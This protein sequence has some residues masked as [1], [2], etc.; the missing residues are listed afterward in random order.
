MLV[1]LVLF[2]CKHLDLFSGQLS[3]DSPCELSCND[4]NKK[5]RLKRA[6]LY[7]KPEMLHFSQLSEILSAPPI[8]TT[9]YSIVL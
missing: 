8:S 2:L 5:A 4:S 9:R 7:L 6:F 1:I 3:K